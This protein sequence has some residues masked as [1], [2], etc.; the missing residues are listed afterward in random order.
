MTRSQEISSPAAA[1]M[2]AASS[3]IPIPERLLVS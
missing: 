3:G 2:L 1:M